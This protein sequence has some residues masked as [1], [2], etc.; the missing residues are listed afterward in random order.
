MY[1]FVGKI[2]FFTRFPVEKL[3]KTQYLFLLN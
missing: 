2:A 3:S 1:Q